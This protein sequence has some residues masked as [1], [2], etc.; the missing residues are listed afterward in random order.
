MIPAVR[1]WVAERAPRCKAPVLEVGAMDMNGSVRDLFPEP[2]TAMDARD[3]I[4]VDL[5]ADVLVHDFALRRF[6]TIVTVETLEHVT[7]PWTA[8]ERMASWLQPGGLM[9]VSVPFMFEYHAFPDDYWRMTHQ[10]LRL[11]FEHAGLAVLECEII[12]THTFGVAQK[13]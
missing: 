7:E 5:V 4:G 12:G 9:L 10:G 2:Y 3:G 6:A 8:I 11:L 13:P 1:E